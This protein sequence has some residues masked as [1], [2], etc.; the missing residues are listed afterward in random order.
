MAPNRELKLLIGLRLHSS[1]NRAILKQTEDFLN[2]ISNLEPGFKIPLHW[3]FSFYTFLDPEKGKSRVLNNLLIEMKTRI[4][5]RGDA[6]VPTGFCGAVHPLLCTDELEKE[7]AWCR[8][9]PWLP[10]AKSEIIMP[11]YPDLRRELYHGIYSS[12]GFR[13]LGLPASLKRTLKE[14]YQFHMKSVPHRAVLFS[15]ALIPLQGYNQILSSVPKSFIIRE[16]VLFILFDITDYEYS[17]RQ[18]HESGF[19]ATF[20]D[21]LSEKFSL[22]LCSLLDAG[23]F[24][25]ATAADIPEESAAAVGKSGTERGSLETSYADQ[26]AMDCDLFQ[27]EPKSRK[28]WL[29]AETIRNKKNKSDSDIRK[30]LDTFSRYGSS[31]QS[32]HAMKP[33]PKGNRILTASMSGS[34]DLRGRAFDVNFYD[35]RFSGIIS[36]GKQKLFGMPAKSY[37]TISG[38]RYLFQTESAFSFQGK[39]ESGLRTILT[40]RLPPKFETKY[41]TKYE[42]KGQTAKVVVDSYFRDESL[43]LII[44]LLITYPIMKAGTI[45]EKVAPFEIPLFTVRK[46]ERILI[47]S[48]YPDRTRYSSLL[49]GDTPIR[50]LYGNRFII[51]KGEISLSIQFIGKYTPRIG[52]LQFCL[53]RKGRR[54]IL[55]ANLSGTYTPVDAQYYSEMADNFSF[56]IGLTP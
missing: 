48:V 28:Q 24:P 2:E 7:L 26:W 31:K 38:K 34:V 44:D 6:A 13:I 12:R 33:A 8:K 51:S 19:V 30:I 18:N 25:E 47:H 11:I 42:T 15:Y 16:R 17:G 21:K 23:L 40:L 9:N 10:G 41:E 46:D 45:L 39:G 1:P 27:S 53:R 52:F 43:D 37:I 29:F 36:K 5:S 49:S 56:K 22:S 32:C 4:K 54:Y 20:L 50:V 3:N 55:F 35:G 14:G